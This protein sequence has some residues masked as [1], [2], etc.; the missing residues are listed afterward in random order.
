[1]LVYPILTLLILVPNRLLPHH[2]TMM[3]DLFYLMVYSTD[4]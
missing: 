4:S 2:I 1:L 3:L